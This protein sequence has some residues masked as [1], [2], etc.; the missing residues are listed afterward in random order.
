MHQPS[1]IGEH[2]TEVNVE[3]TRAKSQK[4]RKEAENARWQA[5]QARAHDRHI[6]YAYVKSQAGVDAHHPESP[7]TAP[8]SF[9]GQA[10]SRGEPSTSGSSAISFSVQQQSAPSSQAVAAPS[11]GA[12][13]R[14][15]DSGYEADQSSSG[16]VVAYAAEPT[17]RSAAP[18][19]VHYE[20]PRPYEPM[21]IGVGA[22]QSPSGGQQRSHDGGSSVSGESSRRSFAS[23]QHCSH[24]G[25]HRSG[26]HSRGGNNG[27]KCCD[28]CCC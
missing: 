27:K 6:S 16:N 17:P 19:A 3:K 13:L 20:Q 9:L 5:E 14:E 7:A 28:D 15:N 25:R 2:L 12:L 26:Q 11:G 23:T 4:Y 24:H 22:G 1:Y 21:T 18:S 10:S 8:S